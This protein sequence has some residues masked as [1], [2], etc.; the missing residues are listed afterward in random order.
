MSS[1]DEGTP[2]PGGSQ[3]HLSLWFIFTVAESD[4]EMQL[5]VIRLKRQGKATNTFPSESLLVA[6][7]A[8][9]YQVWHP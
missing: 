9:V 8:R 3:W 7:C 2:A 5:G 1:G 4:I 6:L